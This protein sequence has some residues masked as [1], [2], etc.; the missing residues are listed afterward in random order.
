MT[1]VVVAPYVEVTQSLAAHPISHV[2]SILGDSDKLDWPDT[3]K[4]S[5]LRLKF[6]DVGYSSGDLKGPTRE[7]IEQLIE[8]A[9]DWGGHSNLLVHCRAGTSRSPAAALIALAAVPRLN[10]IGNFERLINAKAY[11]RPNSTMLRLADSLLEPS[12]DLLEVSKRSRAR[13]EVDDVTLALVELDEP[14]SLF[15]T[16]P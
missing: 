6:D 11:Y 16:P 13:I 14:A 5:V 12:P 10:T 8:F 7:T 15:S 2:I 1:F 3:G 4:R 9:R